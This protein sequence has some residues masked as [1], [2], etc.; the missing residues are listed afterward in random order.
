MLQKVSYFVKN[1]SFRLPGL[2]CSFGVFNP[3]TKISA[4]GSLGNWAGKEIGVRR[5]LGNRALGVL[6]INLAD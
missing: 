1:V 4:A 2:E 6:A 5:D 3:V